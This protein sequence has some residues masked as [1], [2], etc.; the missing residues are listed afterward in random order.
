MLGATVVAVAAA[1]SAVALATGDS[2]SKRIRAC[3]AHGDGALYNVTARDGGRLECRRHDRR[4]SWNRRGRRGQAG[5]QGPAGAVGPQGPKGETGATGAQG[6]KGD[7]GATGAQGPKGDTGAT[8]AQGPKG[9]TGATG[10]QGPKGD[11]GATGPQGPAGVAGVT[12]KVYDLSALF[13]GGQPLPTGATDVFIGGCDSGYSL[14]SGG[15]YTT[16]DSINTPGVSTIVQQSGA[17]GDNAWQVAI[18]NDGSVAVHDFAALICVRVAGAR[19]GPSGA[20]PARGSRWS[21][22]RQ[23]G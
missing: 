14:V 20:S 10:A 15:V 19:P 22:A 13:G 3:V 12:R 5:P 16:E 7:T 21:G 9:D 23:A 1:G 2:P 18:K 4:I 6:P 8:G 17:K 11:T